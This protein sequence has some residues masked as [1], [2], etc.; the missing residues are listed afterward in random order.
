MFRKKTEKASLSF[1]SGLLL[2][3]KAGQQLEA[4]RSCWQNAGSSTF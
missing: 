2:T 1:H 3:V 4:F